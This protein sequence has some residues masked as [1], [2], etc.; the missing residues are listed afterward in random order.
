MFYLSVA[1]KNKTTKNEGLPGVQITT[2]VSS[3]KLAHDTVL[4][5]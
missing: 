3:K 4:T 1:E 2:K 5:G